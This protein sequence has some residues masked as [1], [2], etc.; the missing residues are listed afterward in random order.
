M[1]A[2]PNHKTIF[3]NAPNPDII[4]LIIQRLPRAAAARFLI[5]SST[6]YSSRLKSSINNVWRQY[7]ER[8]F[9]S[10]YRSYQPSE[11]AEKLSWFDVY[12]HQCSKS[13]FFYRQVKNRKLYFAM[14]ADDL[15]VV[16]EFAEQAGT[17]DFFHFIFAGWDGLPGNLLCLASI[18]HSTAIL[19]FIYNKAKQNLAHLPAIDALKLAI[20]CR[21]DIEEIKALYN[22][23][24]ASFLERKNC[25]LGYGSPAQ[26][27]INC[28]NKE[29]IL[30]WVVNNPSFHFIETA[31]L[32]A[33]E[34]GNFE[35]INPY[36]SPSKNKFWGNSF[37]FSI[38]GTI[39]GGHSLQ[40]Q[41]L[42]DLFEWTLEKYPYNSDKL[43]RNLF[44]FIRTAI[45]NDQKKCL[46]ILIAFKTKKAPVLSQY[47]GPTLNKSILVLEAVQRV[48]HA[49]FKILIQA[50]L[51]EGVDLNLTIENGWEPIMIGFDKNKEQENWKF[52]TECGASLQTH[53]DKF[54]NELRAHFI[55][56]RSLTLCL[57]SF[58][59]LAR[60]SLLT[61]IRSI[62][63]LNKLRQ[64]PSIE[65]EFFL[66][67]IRDML[68]AD[69][70]NAIAVRCKQ[71]LPTEISPQDLK[72]FGI[73]NWL[74][75]S[76]KVNQ[77]VPLMVL[78]TEKRAE[79]K[80]QLEEYQQKCNLR[81]PSDYKT[82]LT[83]FGQTINFG[84]NAGQKSHAV[85]V[86]IAIVD[87]TF[88]EE[89]YTQQ[90]LNTHFAALNN[91]ELGNIFGKTGIDLNVFTAR[92]REPLAAAEL[93]L[94]KDVLITDVK[95][96]RE[97]ATSQELCHLRRV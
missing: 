86:A 48:R 81:E 15:A 18:N 63:D 23:K 93:I 85:K 65:S 58:G 91:G 90:E 55:S 35:V 34:F 2:R 28:D 47:F 16:V 80:G 68:P 33:C 32:N 9:P 51:D 10:V 14:M 92:G 43:K 50:I 66:A 39:A 42:L 13:R 36:L 49:T 37:Y 30:T 29:V 75:I 95:N 70:L 60:P 25:A 87:G 71:P 46:E 45:I 88:D 4:A 11:H 20:I 54:S 67:A 27:A 77:L 52:L 44:E 31:L 59:N 24:P 17:K 53:T 41:S 12:K 79:I 72:K 64:L 74:L 8:D 62:S 84:F 5:S 94:K 97:D 89:K 40:L 82:K 7:V 26:E 83:L 1:N 78:S 69:V 22:D 56:N 96:P 57:L 19:N 76:N 3:L 21:R 73:K 61:A 6:L 38:V